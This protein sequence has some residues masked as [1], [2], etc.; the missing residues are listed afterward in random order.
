MPGCA[1]CG[2]LD[3]KNGAGRASHF[4]RFHRNLPAAPPTSQKKLQCPRCPLIFLR[5]SS[6][7]Q[8]LTHTHGFQ[9]IGG[10]GGAQ[11]NGDDFADGDD[12]GPAEHDLDRDAAFYGDVASSSSSGSRSDSSSS[13]S[14]SGS[15]S[16]DEGASEEDEN[17]SSSSVSGHQSD[18][19]AEGAQQQQVHPDP[20]ANSSE[21]CLCEVDENA[22]PDTSKSETRCPCLAARWLA[23]NFCLRN[24]LADNLTC[25]TMQV[26]DAIGSA[27]IYSSEEV[28]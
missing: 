8:H 17:S 6:L 11:A 2:I 16:S 23:I 15:S 5:G 25:N 20:D 22:F 13:S 26:C 18:G 1:Q 14:S 24:I 9:S 10:G 21:D 4:N 3:F 27:G 28:T 7:A 19:E 12:A